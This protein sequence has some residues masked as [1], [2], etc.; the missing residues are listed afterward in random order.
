MEDYLILKPNT[1]K[2]GTGQMKGKNVSKMLNKE[3]LGGGGG[4]G[5]VCRGAVAHCTG[6]SCLVLEAGAENLL[7]LGSGFCFA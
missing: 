2:C 6:N 4:G 3:R 5:R 1:K 7:W